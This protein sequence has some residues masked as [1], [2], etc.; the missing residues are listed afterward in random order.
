MVLCIENYNLSNSEM[1]QVSTIII[2]WIMTKHNFVEK[3]NKLFEDK[4]LLYLRKN[5]QC[6]V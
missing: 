3:Q 2:F 4:S 5:I 6:L 1:F